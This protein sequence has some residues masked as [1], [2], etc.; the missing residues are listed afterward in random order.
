MPDNKEWEYIQRMEVVERGDFLN[1][2]K[3][4]IFLRT[5][6]EIILILFDCN[7]LAWVMQL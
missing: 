4:I 3:K 6:Y 5:L 2:Q 1:K 7:K